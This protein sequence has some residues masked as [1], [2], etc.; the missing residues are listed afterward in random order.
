MCSSLA[1]S[2]VTPV[3]SI[4]GLP[5]VLTLSQRWA[6]ERFVLSFSVI[7]WAYCI[8]RRRLGVMYWFPPFPYWILY[9]PWSCLSVFED[10][11]IIYCFPFHSVAEYR[12]MVATVCELQWLSYLLSDFGIHLP[13]PVRLFCDNQVALHHGESRISWVHE[14][15]WDWLPCGQNCL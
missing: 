14:T 15:Q 5:N 4:A 9:L 12:S 3:M 2:L 8:L 13:L 10:Q 1:N 6:V 11:E 7:L